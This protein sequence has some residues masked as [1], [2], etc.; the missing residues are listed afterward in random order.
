V[1]RLLAPKERLRLSTERCAREL[2]FEHRLFATREHTGVLIL[3]SALEHRVVILGDSGIDQYVQA[4]GWTVH[5][6]RIAQAIRDG[7]AA[8]GVCEVTRAIGEVLAQHLPKRAD[9]IDE[10][11]NQVRAR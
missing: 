1:L 5:V 3:V 8:E 9:D 2:F 11:S 10:L 6:Q 7:R 4:S